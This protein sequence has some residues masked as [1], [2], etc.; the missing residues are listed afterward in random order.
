MGPTTGLHH[1]LLEGF[2]GAVVATSANRSGEPLCRDAHADSSLLESLADGVLSHGLA[3]VNR[4]DDSVMRVSAG[5]PMVLR[6][7]RG[8]APLALP[9]PAA[10]ASR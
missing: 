8:L 9:A 2:G 6:L 5:R 7:G 10:T 3:I 1:L 4:L